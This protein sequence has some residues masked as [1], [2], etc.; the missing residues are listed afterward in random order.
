MPSWI[1][2]DDGASVGCL[3]GRNNLLP[4]FE[5]DLLGEME[6][7]VSARSASALP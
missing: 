4:L 6:S 1:T 2:D 5:T 3:Y 7:F